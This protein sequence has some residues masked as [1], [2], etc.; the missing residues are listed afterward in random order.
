MDPFDGRVVPTFIR[1]ALKNEPFTIF[2]DGTQTRSFCYI[3]DL[4]R[5]IISM[6]ASSDSGP[7]NLGNPRENTLLELAEIVTDIVGG[8]GGII[9]RPLPE[10]DPRQRNPDISKAK[11]ILTWEPNISLESGIQKTADWMFARLGF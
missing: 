6:G 4:V 10:D 9:Y 2:G 7:I 11:T 5:G 3:D 1:Q 8:T